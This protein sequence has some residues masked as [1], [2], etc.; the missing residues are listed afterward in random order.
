MA[1][2]IPIAF[3]SD[4]IQ[5]AMSF[6]FVF[7]VIFAL[8]CYSGIFS[9]RDKEGHTIE[10]SHRPTLGI[11]AAVI[12]FSAA[13][14]S[15]FSAFLMQTIPLAVIALIPLFFIIFAYKIFE[16]GEKQKD[17]VPVVIGIVALLAV[18]AGIWPSVSIYVRMF[19]ISPELIISAAGI[20]LVI[21]IFG[22]A[23]RAGKQ[24]GQASQP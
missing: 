3:P 16:G 1:L 22:F 8:L 20:M 23:Y 4:I 11:I 19:G 10:K 7:A 2:P 6:L 14:Y 17:L 9:R 24:K 12:G 18:L 13:S 21:M 5:F 15:P